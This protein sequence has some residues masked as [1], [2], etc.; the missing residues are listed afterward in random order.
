[1]LRATVVT[2]KGPLG[3]A[4]FVCQGR[5]RKLAK[6]A[7][8]ALVAARP[9]NARKPASSVAGFIIGEFRAL[10]ASEAALKREFRM[11]AGA[12]AGPELETRFVAAR[13][14]IAVWNLFW[15]ALLPLAGAT[16]ASAIASRWGGTEALIAAL[17]AFISLVFLGLKLLPKLQPL[18][19]RWLA[20]SA[21]SRNQ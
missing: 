1:M 12:T 21:R 13:P 6:E 4:S 5:S 17:V 2:L 18:L 3:E 16:A 15:T 9:G 11:V 10:G 14:R 8:A 19:A 7:F 20:A